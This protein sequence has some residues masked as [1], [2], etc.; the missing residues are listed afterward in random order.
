MTL[1]NATA[2]TTAAAGL[3][4]AP[5]LAAAVSLGALT[6]AGGTA[7]LAADLVPAVLA[8]A[9]LG[10]VGLAVM[11]GLRITYRRQATRIEPLRR[12]EL[13]DLAERRR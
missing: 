5:A 7:G 8:W 6:T 4:G 3:L 1:N 2:I 10:L 12:Y 9:A 13:A 11:V